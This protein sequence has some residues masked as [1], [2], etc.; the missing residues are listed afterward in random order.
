MSENSVVTVSDSLAG[1]DY[2]PTGPVDIEIAQGRIVTMKPSSS[3]PTG[4]RRLAM[5]A[6]VDAHDHARPL[7]T[8][9]FAGGGRPLETWLP[10]LALMPA[11]DPYLAAVAALGRAAR[12]GCAG[13]MVH[14]TRPMGPLPLPEEATLIAKAAADVGVAI[15]FAVSMRD[16]HPLVYGDHQPLLDSLPEATRR[17]VE[18]HW[19]RVPPPAGDQIALVAA[20]AEAVTASQPG[21][22][23]DVQYGPNGVQWC[24]RA[25]LEGIA[26]ASAAS[27]RRIH[28][29]FLE[30]SAQRQ[31]ADATF[32]SGIVPHLREIGLLSPRLT[33]AHC[34]W[35]RPDELDI[36][37]ETGARVAVNP[38][39]NLH[40]FSGIAP[41][42]EMRKRGVDVAMGLDGC[43]LDEDD[44]GLREMRLFRLLNAG[45]GF[46]ADFTAAEVLRACCRIGRDGIGLETG[47]ILASGMPADMLVLDLDALD[48]DA[49]TAVDPRDLLLARARCEHIVSLYSRGREIVRD[50][51]LVSIDLE[52]AENELRSSYRAALPAMA[53]KTKAWNALEPEIAAF[54]RD[55]HGC[56]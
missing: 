20:V 8:T 23:V 28:M 19:L 47:G 13:V 5:P 26:E 51:K 50:G 29:H 37:A 35:A 32:R 31:W 52:A 16:S 46:D 33:L 53:D 4:R 15:G 3:I 48:R 49:L 55:F 2:T 42:R 6:L 14:L 9:S 11:V 36:I 21:I 56:C 7:S 34:T 18:A 45:T 25:M 1:P 54:Y 10:R 43:T 30:T 17:M 38:S 24:S 40:L 12:G 39:S 41:A 22:H 27:G 44:D